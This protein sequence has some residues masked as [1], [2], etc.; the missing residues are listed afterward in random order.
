MAFVPRVS[1]GLESADSQH[2]PVADR[3]GKIPAGGAGLHDRAH[4]AP[5][6]RGP[7]KA[8]TAAQLIIDKSEG[9]LN[10]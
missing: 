3:G 6:Q 2:S 1:E 8:F 7:I 5:I 9:N 4:C 10:Y